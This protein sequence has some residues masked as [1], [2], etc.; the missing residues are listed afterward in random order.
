[1]FSTSMAFVREVFDSET[2]GFADMSSKYKWEI[3]AGY[4]DKIKTGADAVF[5]EIMP[6][7][8]FKFFG[9]AYAAHENYA[10]QQLAAQKR[11]APAVGQFVGK[12]HYKSGTFYGYFTQTVDKLAVDLQR[13]GMSVFQEEYREMIQA[14]EDAGIIIADMHGYNF[15]VIGD[16]FV[17]IDFS[18]SSS[19]AISEKISEM[20][21]MAEVA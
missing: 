13:K 9:Y 8:G 12:F 14:A 10:M 16:R 6:G 1:M 17:I 18:R 11:I 20:E 2:A 21:K 15:G 4:S 7:I 5:V 19:P 3:A